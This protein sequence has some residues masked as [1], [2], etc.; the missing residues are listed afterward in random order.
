MSSI[1]LF[2]MVQQHDG[3][4]TQEFMLG[5]CYHGPSPV[6]DRAMI[7]RHNYETDT[8]CVFLNCQCRPFNFFFLQRESFCAFCGVPYWE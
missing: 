8:A 2:E 6:L 7:H 5:A 3:S 4:S 1:S